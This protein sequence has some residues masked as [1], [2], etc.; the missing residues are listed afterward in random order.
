V[1]GIAGIINFDQ[2]PVNPGQIEAM[3]SALHTRGPHGKMVHLAGE[4]AL[5]Q[6]LLDTHPIPLT[7]D[8]S[9]THLNQRWVLVLDGRIDNRSDLLAWL[10]IQDSP[11]SFLGDGYL[12]LA[13][14]EKWGPSC[15][16]HLL[17]DFVFAIWDQQEQRLFCARDHF[18]VRPFYYFH[19]P[20]FFIFASSPYAILA[21]RKIAHR[22]NEARIADFLTGLEGE[23][24]TS[25]FYQDLQRLP[26]GHSLLVKS[27]QASLARYW[28]LRPAQ[29][30]GCATDEDYLEGFRQRFAEAVRCRL[31]N[32]AFTAISLSGGIDSSAVLAIARQLPDQEIRQALITSSF[33]S[34]CDPHNLE[35]RHIQAMLDQGG[36]LPHTVSDEHMLGRLDELITQ[37]QGLD[38]P[39]D[40]LQNAWRS[41][42]TQAQAQNMHAFLDGIDAD[43]LLSGAY[44]V[45]FLWRAG[46]VRHALGETILAGGMLSGYLLH[47]WS[48]LYQSLGVAIAPGWL[49]HMRQAAR[50][51]KALPEAI[52][53]S[54]IHPS[55]AQAVHLEDRLARYRSY[56]IPASVASQ[57]EAH[58][59]NLLHPHLQAA[60]ERYDRIAASYSIESRHPFLDVRL[61][62]FCLGL[63]WWLKTQHGWSKMILR[64]SMEPLLPP[65]IT[66]RK[67]RTHLNW[68]FSLEIL[69][70]RKDYFRQLF[71]ESRPALSQYIDFPKLEKNWRFFF[72]NGNEDAAGLI[73]DG[74]AL[75]LWLRRQERFL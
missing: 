29:D 54:L 63:P 36:M 26:A 70:Q 65:E 21:A 67:D 50:Q 30:T 75:A 24:T 51:R 3:L 46:K 43:N 33:I 66:W 28:E 23:D 60:L 34:S 56:E 61:V 71:D 11:P 2:T 22:L 35:N 25:T 47:R 1:S 41:M 74:I 4:V 13:A 58:R 38:E 16:G 49:R 14:F 12:I 42:Y 53:T 57:I 48:L 8:R 7:D 44:T 39:F 73:W 72:A 31:T 59:A 15:I 64:R 9:L 18:G 32:P 6:V 55:F 17:G 69:R 27:A 52:R 5:G 20:S 10:S 68:P 45:H 40:R 62:E 37:L 19:T